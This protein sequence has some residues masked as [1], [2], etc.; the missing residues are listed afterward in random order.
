[1]ADMHFVLLGIRSGKTA[2]GARV[3]AFYPQTETAIIEKAGRTGDR[4]P[5]KGEAGRLT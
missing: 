3:R 1:M 5:R 4:L 2:C